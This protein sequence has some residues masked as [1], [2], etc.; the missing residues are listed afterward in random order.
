MDGAELLLL[1]TK[2]HSKIGET[3]RPPVTTKLILVYVFPGLGSFGE[4]WNSRLE[5]LLGNG[6]TRVEGSGST[7][8]VHQSKCS[9]IGGMLTIQIVRI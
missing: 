2:P 8:V 4:F 1:S 3:V 7:R 6:R 5:V 9:K